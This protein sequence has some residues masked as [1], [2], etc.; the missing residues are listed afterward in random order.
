MTDAA[1][2]ATATATVAT[3][4][5]PSSTPPPEMPPST[6]PAGESQ[7]SGS[8]SEAGEATNRSGQGTAR[9]EHWAAAQ[10]AH[11]DHVTGD[12]VGGDKIAGHKFEMRIEDK[13]VPLRELSVDLA[14]PVEQAFVDPHEWQQ[15]IERFRGSR[16]TVVR[17]RAGQGKDACAIRLLHTD[18]DVIYQINP[19]VDVA[20]LA[21]SVAEQVAILSD[22]DKRVGFLLCQPTQAARLRGFTLQTLEEIL[23][24]ARARLV[25][26]LPPAVRPADE[27]LANYVVDLD[28]HPVDRWKIVTGHLGWRCA[29]PLAAQLT[30]SPA[31]R[32]L[33]EELMLDGLDCRAAADLAWIISSECTD[34]GQ[35][36]VLRVRERL[37]R[38]QDE[39]FDL[40]FDSLR[41]ADERSFA[42]A[43]AV[44]DGLPYEEVSAA[45]RRLRNKLETG[46]PLVIS[47]NSGGDGNE[48]RTAQ[49]D[50]FRTPTARLLQTLRAEQ[51][52]TLVRYAYGMVPVHTVS[53]KDSAYPRKVIERIWR[54]YQLQPMLLDWLGELILS[55]SEPV[56]FF[57]ASTLGVLSR[58]SFDYLC[59]VALHRW[60]NSKDPRVRE[61]VAYSM[62]EP[63]G[64]PQLA[65]SV[66]TIV[67]GWF[68]DA[69]QSRVQATAA[70]AY[71]VGVGDLD[72]D[73]AI[74]RLGRLAT[75][76][77]YPVAA[78]VGD[79]LADLI[80][81]APAQTAPH[82]CR[83]L[84]SW[85]EDRLRRRPAHLA[86]LIL[87]SSLVVWD[88]DDDGAEARWPMLL[89]LLR[90]V[91][92]L[93]EPLITLWAKVL[94][95]TVLKAQAHG[96]LTAWAGVA[97]SDRQQL[98]VLTRLIRAIAARNDRVRRILLDL[99]ADWVASERL[100][101]LPRA[102]AA[103]VAQ[104]DF[105]R[106]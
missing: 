32:D 104:L 29:G 15:I 64:D 79:A 25:I 51:S 35:I 75:V 17:G 34:D 50:R 80:L 60:A 42:V 2:P 87:A 101:P 16:S 81:Q 56:R 97:E 86:F 47:P 41:D 73:T 91:D 82:V 11:S 59:T 14:D 45:A 18:T 99:A 6:T 62:R 83:A 105:R 19:E 85:F 71:G 77:S 106:S 27:S 94:N 3:P 98:E 89:H 102:H 69:T 48:L 30:K 103:V 26:T 76:D 13:V 72:L 20:G 54:G 46:R 37:R 100:V 78:G 66:S 28:Q 21:D 70:R 63:A 49:H 68:A 43:L 53:Y 39:S 36:N 84:L 57:A 31:V 1:S 52:H 44:L 90:T 58:Y 92:E 33:F 61:A 96:V 9:R 95:E 93:R 65:G 5:P 8:W 55:P 10:N 67:A 24:A 38:R 12:K 88:E 4:E 22:G 23:Y 74:D 7:D 40:W